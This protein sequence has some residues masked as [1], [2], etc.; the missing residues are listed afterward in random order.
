VTQEIKSLPLTSPKSSSQTIQKEL[1]KTLETQYNDFNK[2]LF[3]TH[4]QTALVLFEHAP[5]LGVGTG[6]FYYSV[7]QS[8]KDIL[9][10]IKTLCPSTMQATDLSSTAHNIYLQILAEQGVIGIFIFITI[11]VYLVYFFLQNKEDIFVLC[12]G[13]S[14][15]CFLLQGLTFSYFAY[16]EMLYLFF[17]LLGLYCKKD[18]KK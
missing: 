11:L 13:M 10:E 5:V 9:C 8:H 1:E 18:K 16:P 6:L 12:L 17:L 14:I 7:T 4:W 2:N 15:F 3:F